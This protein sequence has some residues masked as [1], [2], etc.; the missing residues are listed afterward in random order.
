MGP[1][2]PAPGVRPPPGP[3]PGG[4]TAPVV[5]A[6]ILVSD[7][8]GMR[9]RTVVTDDRG[10]YHVNLPAGTYRIEMAPLTQGMF[11]KDLPATVTITEGKETR[12]DIL[13]DTGIR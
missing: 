7:L 6:K 2:P 8:M 10:A 13:V 1:L 12:L 4:S 3:I 11:T 9:S 5:G